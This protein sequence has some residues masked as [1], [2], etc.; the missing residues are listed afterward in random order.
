MVKNPKRVLVAPLDWGLGHATRCIPI[1]DYL[2]SK[3][4]EVFIATN[5][6]PFELL[7]K[8]YPNLTLIRLTSYDIKYYSESIHW[9]ITMQVSKLLRAIWGEHQQ[10]KKIVAQYQIDAIIS[11]NRFGC[12]VKN[13][14][15]VFISHQLHLI[16]GPNIIEKWVNKFNHYFIRKFEECWIPD[17]EGEPNLSGRLSH[18]SP[19]SNTKYL[20]ALTRIKPLK[21][22]TIYDVAFILS[23]P[24][25]QRTKLENK[26][27]EQAKH[28]PYRLLLVQGKPEKEDHYVEDN[29]E[30]FSYMTSKQLNEAIASSGLVVCRSG[31]STIMDLVAMGKNALLIPTPGQT[32]QEYLAEYYMEQG[33]CFSQKQGELNLEEGINQA[34]V[35]DGFGRFSYDNA[36]LKEVLDD[37]VMNL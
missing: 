4:I 11:D 15:N 37:F 9:N 26:I 10:I 8:E 14:K 25:P 31:Y 18:P 32:E 16:A 6:R 3:D 17:F 24:E 35:Y 19:F 2:L 29:M 22:E 13:K 27:L 20:G 33:I 5:G 34:D 23:G 1:I 30:V 7:K 12:F 36:K 21:G 28:I